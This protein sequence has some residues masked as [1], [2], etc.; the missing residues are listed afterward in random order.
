MTLPTELLP[1]SNLNGPPGFRFGGQPSPKIRLAGRSFG[2]GWWRG[3]DSNLRSPE[4]RWV[5]SPVPLTARPPLQKSAR[6]GNCLQCFGLPP[7]WSP[8]SLQVSRNR[9]AQPFIQ[10]NRRQPRSANPKFYSTYVSRSWSWREDLNP[11]P[12]DYKSAALPA[13]LRQH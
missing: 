13:E 12:A 5:Y 1:L 9:L 7:K 3:E 10:T 2:E 4:G 8:G 11:R 6:H